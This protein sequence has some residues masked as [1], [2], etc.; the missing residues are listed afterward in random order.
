[1]IGDNGMLITPKHSS[2]VFL[3]EIITDIPTTA[4]PYP[5]KHCNGCGACKRACPMEKIGGCLSALTQKKGELS[6]AEEQA[7]L[8]F[9]SVWGCDICQEVCPHTQKAISEGTIYTDIEYF[10]TALLPS[11]TRSALDEMTDLEFSRRAY[12]WRGRAVIGRNLDLIKKTTKA[13]KIEDD[14]C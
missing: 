13:D 12:S 14:L 4:T 1:M 10:K 6:P 3:G 8:E 2:Y 11:L 5:I 7:I 9:G